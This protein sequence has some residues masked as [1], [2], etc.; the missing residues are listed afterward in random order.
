MDP[1]GVQQDHQVQVLG[2]EAPNGAHQRDSEIPLLRHPRFVL[3]VLGLL[4]A[5]ICCI[6]ASIGI[7]TARDDVANERLAAMIGIAAIFAI[8]LALLL[9]DGVRLLAEVR[10]KDGVI[11]LDTGKK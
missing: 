11:V 8:F 9:V 1:A 2:V 4:T 10:L 3:S 6:A 5:A 7:A